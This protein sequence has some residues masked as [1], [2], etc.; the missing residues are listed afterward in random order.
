MRPCSFVIDLARS[1]KADG[2]IISQ[3]K[4]LQLGSKSTAE[5]S[6]TT[7]PTSTDIQPARFCGLFAALS[8]E[9]TA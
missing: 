6:S 4:R 8:P 7:A 9:F 1:V 5:L 3:T 2:R